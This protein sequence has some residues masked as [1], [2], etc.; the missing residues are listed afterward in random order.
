MKIG[1]ACIPLIIPYKTTRKFILKSYNDELF[2]STSKENILDLKKI[3]EFNNKNNIKLF[4]ISSDIIPFGS[5]DILNIPWSKIFKSELLTLGEYI[6]SNNLRVSM[7]PGQYTVLNSPQAD[8]VSK[9]IKDLEYHN[10]FLN[11]LNLDYTHKI[12]LHVGG[13]YGDKS[14]SS[15]RFISNFKLLSESLKKRLIIENDEKNYS[16]HE[17]LD[18]AEK[19]NIPVVY[20]NLHEEC[21][22]KHKPDSNKI[23]K[24]IKHTWKK[25]DGDIK[26]HYANQAYDKKIGSHSPYLYGN[27]FLNY[28]KETSSNDFDIMLEVKDKDISSLKA[29]SLLKELNSSICSEEKLNILNNYYFILKCYSEDSFKYS[30]ELL[31]NDSL[32]SFYSYIENLMRDTPKESSYKNVLKELYILLEET[33]DKK[34][35]THFHKLMQENK[36]SKAKDYLHKCERR[37]SNLPI[38]NYFYYYDL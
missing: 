18:I 38:Y 3:L 13:V 21:F 33:L 28:I 25:E 16:L 34:E 31:F 32:S 35:I 37:A 14:S 17:V 7:H 30:K 20:D 4:R 27:D 22:E 5:H 6:K 11:S 15:K 8:V 23:L 36:L 29:L 9:S 24:E 2:L 1:Y 26:V 19:C 12:V 10:D